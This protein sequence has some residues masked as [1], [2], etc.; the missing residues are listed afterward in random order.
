[1]RYAALAC[2]IAIAI[3]PVPSFGQEKEPVPTSPEHKDAPLAKEKGEV[4]T[5]KTNCWTSEQGCAGLTT[6]GGFDIDMGCT[7]WWNNG[8]AGHSNFTMKAK[9][10]SEEHVQYGDTGA[11]VPLQYAPPDGSTRF[12]IWVHN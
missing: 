10:T 7:I 6:V 11:C 8:A 5:M 4:K 1:M 2:L 3:A 12:W 9:Q